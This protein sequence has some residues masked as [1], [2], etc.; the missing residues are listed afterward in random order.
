[1]SDKQDRKL[2]RISHKTEVTARI[3]ETSRFVGFGMVAWVFAQH[4]SGAPFAESYL[5][6]FGPIVRVAGVLGVLAILF[7]YL[8]YIAAYFSVQQALKNGDDGYAFD[9]DGIVMK[10]QKGL[11][12]AKQISA[13]ASALIVVITFSLSINQPLPDVKLPELDVEEVSG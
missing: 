13:V 11:F 9:H 10:L 8:Q 1:M 6:A 12:W 4:A 5:S 2:D 7:D 3:S